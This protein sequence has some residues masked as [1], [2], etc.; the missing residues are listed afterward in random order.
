MKSVLNC[1]QTGLFHPHD[2]DNLYTGALRPG[3]VLEVES[4]Q[5]EAVDLRPGH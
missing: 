4:M 2:A 5:F 1:H 3:H